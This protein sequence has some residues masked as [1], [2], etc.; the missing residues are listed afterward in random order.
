M[1]RSR[2]KIVC[3]SAAIAAIGAFISVCALKLPVAFGNPPPPVYK[4]LRLLAAAEAQYATITRADVEPDVE[5]I[6]DPSANP[7][8]DD[9]PVTVSLPLG[10]EVKLIGGGLNGWTHSFWVHAVTE[11]GQTTTEYFH[12]QEGDTVIIG[13]DTDV[14][15][16][17]LRINE[18]PS[19]IDGGSPPEDT[20]TS[21][22]PYRFKWQWVVEGTPGFYDNDIEGIIGPASAIGQGGTPGQDDSIEYRWSV[23]LGEFENPET[24][25]ATPVYEPTEAGWA[26]L[27]LAPKPDLP[28]HWKVQN[29]SIEIYEDHLARDYANF[30]TGIPCGPGN[31][32][33]EAYSI[34]IQMEAW[35]CHGS[36]KHA[37]NGTTCFSGTTVDWVPVVFT[38]PI[39]WAGVV[40]MLDRGDVVSFWGDPI[41]GGAPILH[42]SHTCLSGTTMYGA[43]NQPAADFTQV[44]SYTWKWATCTSEEYFNNINAAYQSAF[45]R[46]LLT[47]VG[48]HNKP[49]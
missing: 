34:P 39:D 25:T 36:A 49:N 29:R 33:F 41:G 23:T 38:A 43:N 30:G 37:Y 15:A 1:N 20:F 31:W 16:A 44:P 45:G 13:G 24:R 7:A 47:R 6:R 19:P 5:Y 26:I 18:P 11:S 9:F 42:H 21:S 32:T 8:R 22:S 14:T 12:V 40:G 28:Y 46:D 3:F 4:T 10:T 17:F 2:I 35:N 27:K 48:V